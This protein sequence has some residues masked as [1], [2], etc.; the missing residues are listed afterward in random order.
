MCG[1]YCVRLAQVSSF[2][3]MG[4]RPAFC[5]AHKCG[6]MIDV[7]SKVCEA[8]GCLKR[9]SFGEVGQQARYC[10]NHRPEGMVDVVHRRCESLRCEKHPTYGFLGKR[11]RF[12]SSHVVRFSLLFF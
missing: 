10:S 7:K 3:F 6:D 2:G 1:L 4:E 12:C 9:S 5:A 11:R 8:N